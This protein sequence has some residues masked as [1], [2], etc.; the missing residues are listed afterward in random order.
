MD[1]RFLESLIRVIETGSIAQ[2]ARIQHLTA[3]AV[4]QRIKTLEVEFGTDL[5]TRS[6]HRAKPTAACAR[7]LNRARHIVKEVDVLVDNLRPGFFSNALRIGVIS[8]QWSPLLP[9]Q[10]DV[11]R[12]HSPETRISLSLNTSRILYAGLLNGEFDAIIIEAPNFT[13]PRN[14][15]ST[16][17]RQEPLVL[18][19]NCR[20]DK[21][22]REILQENKY[23]EYLPDP[24]AINIA[25]KY[26]EDLSLVLT[27]I[28]DTGSLESILALVSEGKGASLVPKWPGLKTNSRNLFITKIDEGKYMRDVV[29]LTSSDCYHSDFFDRLREILKHR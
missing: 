4:S 7:I 28:C 16:L 22:P 19:S 3:A 13:V 20:Y 12:Q 8:S 2:A 11:L 17:I 15:R 1:S 9:V 6:G 26:L 5:L 25:T 18:I 21:S 24:F 29:L 10:L 23:I 27:P 14:I